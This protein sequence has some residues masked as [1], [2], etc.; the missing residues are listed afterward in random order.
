[1][2]AG[3]GFGEDFLAAR[4]DRRRSVQVGSASRCVLEVVRRCR[5][6]EEQRQVWRLRLVG[7]PVRRVLAR[8]VDAERGD[9]LATDQGPEVGGPLFAEQT[10]V[11]EHPVQRAEGAHRVGTV[12]EHPRGEHGVGLGV[13]PGQRTVGGNSRHVV[14]LAVVEVATGEFLLAGMGRQFDPRLEV[15]DRVHGP[16][17][18]DVVTGHQRGIQCSRPRGVEQLL[19]VA[20]LVRIPH[21]D[22]IDPE[23]LGS[24]VGVEVGPGGLVGVGRWIGRVWPDVAEAAGH[25]HPIG[26]HQLAVV[27]VAGIFVIA[28]GVP[29][30][31]GLFVEVRVGEQAQ[32]DDAGAVAVVGTGGNVLAP[33]ADFHPRI[34]FFVFERVGATGR[35]TAVQPQAV[36]VLTRTFGF[37]VARL[38]D[39]AEVVPAVVAAG[40]EPRVAGNG[41]EEIEVADAVARQLVPELVVAGGPDDPVVATASEG[42]HRLLLGDAGNEG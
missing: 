34:L 2:A 41:L 3:A 9:R 13:E 15:V 4:Q 26:F 12:L 10:D 11:D 14:E 23:I 42:V 30:F 29:V 40:L 21:E 20:G 28:L 6:E 25:A 33:G 19:R 39:H 32:A 38:V 18:V 35:I 22:A 17:V 16:R 5:G 8:H 1:M 37:H 27:V 31:L 24:G 36:A 7:V